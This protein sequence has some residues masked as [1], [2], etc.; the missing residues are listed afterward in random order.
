M[1]RI[2]LFVAVCI[3][4]CSVVNSFCP[5]VSSIGNR[6]TMTSLAAVASK[7]K[8]KFN[9]SSNKW[10]RS[11]KDDGAYPYDAVGALLRHGPSAFLTRVTNAEEYEQYVLN[12]MAEIGVDRGEAT[13]NIDAKLNNAADWAYQKMEENKGKPKVDYTAL[14]AKDAALAL[15]WAFFIT[16]L[17]VSVIQQTLSQLNDGMTAYSTYRG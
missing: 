4:T 13:G 9:K 15:I 14:K 3:S 16:P 1:I 7:T 8:P 5:S 11:P 12:Y 2:T 17:T 10:E 6:Q